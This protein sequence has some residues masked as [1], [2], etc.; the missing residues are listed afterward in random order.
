MKFLSGFVLGIVSCFVVLFVIGK[1]TEQSTTDEGLKLFS[2]PK[3]CITRKN[4]RVFQALPNGRALAK[5]VNASFDSP[6]MYLVGM[7]GETFYD[8]EIV[9]LPGKQCAMQIGT[10]FYQTK[11]K[12]YKTV[13]AVSISWQE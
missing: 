13:P 9:K 11:N 5:E 1:V 10:Y 6:V 4:L 3:E 7:E 2:E 12:D 8:D